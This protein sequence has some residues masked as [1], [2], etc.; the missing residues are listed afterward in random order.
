M[1]IDIDWSEAPESAEYGRKV[2]TGFDWYKYVDGTFVYLTGYG[3][4]EEAV[5]P[6]RMCI[7]RPATWSGADLPPVG[8]VCEHFGTADHTNWIEVQVIGHAHVRHHDVAFFEY[9][10]GTNGYTVSYST[11][12]NFRPLRTPEQIAA[13]E[14]ESAIQ[15]IRDDIGWQRPQLGPCPVAQLYDAGYRKQANND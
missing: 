10:I 3:T 12:T 8:T 7:P 15:A 14:R 9:M 13:E 1:K 5:T 11:H 6:P 2:H 4:W